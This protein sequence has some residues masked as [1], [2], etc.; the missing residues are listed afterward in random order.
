MRFRKHAVLTRITIID[1]TPSVESILVSVAAYRIC[2]S[3]VCHRLLPLSPLCC[4][5]DDGKGR[6]C[7]YLFFIFIRNG[8]GDERHQ[9]PLAYVKSVF[10]SH[11][12]LIG[13]LV[14]EHKHRIWRTKCCSKLML[15]ATRSCINIMK[16]SIQ[17]SK[18]EGCPL[19][20]RDEA[21][22]MACTKLGQVMLMSVLI[23][24][25]RS[26]STTYCPHSHCALP[27]G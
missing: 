7:F 3:S 8:C 24:T 23:L 16:Y 21:L 5:N 18:P 14:S 11:P 13:L 25:I 2:T 4:L 6:R 27:A 19:L 12:L 22:F 15:G 26:R 1:F 17:L 9:A 20:I 10:I